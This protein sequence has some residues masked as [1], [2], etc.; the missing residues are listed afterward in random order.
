MA[1]CD[2][3]NEN[4]HSTVLDMVDGALHRFEYVGIG[5]IDEGVATKGDRARYPRVKG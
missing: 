1:M 3:R 5:W 4:K 2:G